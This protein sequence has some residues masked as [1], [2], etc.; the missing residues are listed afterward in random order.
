MKAKKLTALLGLSL[1][2]LMLAPAA[3]SA[4]TTTA[5]TEADATFQGGDPNEVYLVQPGT[6]DNEI[7]PNAASG[8]TGDPG[9]IR[10]NWV[11]N[12]SFGTLNISAG[13]KSHSS[14]LSATN[15]YDEVASGG[16]TDKKIPQFV[17]IRDTRGTRGAF[18]LSAT[19]TVF[20][21]EGGTETLDN[22]RIQ[23][24]GVKLTNNV[25][26]RDASGAKDGDASAILAGP[27][28]LASLTNGALTELSTSSVDILKTQASQ[29]AD[30]SISSLV[31]D[32]TYTSQADYSAATHNDKVKLFVPAGE[33]PEDG[34]TYKSTI[35]WSLNDTP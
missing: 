31:F 25:I 22:T 11:P 35:T 17:Q 27:T 6:Y 34:A 21:K 23:F 1:C 32:D 2:G 12:F 20:T 9:L 5:T 3:A 29:T 33:Q 19:A 4:A 16:A 18:S 24:Y 28:Q 26:D 13:S 15:T 14:V 7:T 8:K 10:I 30:G